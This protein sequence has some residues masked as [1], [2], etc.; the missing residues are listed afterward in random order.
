MRVAVEKIEGV[1]GAEV[2][3]NDG[4]VAIRL[5]DPNRVSLA[6]V[7]ETIRKQGFT[8]RDATVVVRGIARRN[9]GGLELRVPG[10]GDVYQLSGDSREVAEVEASGGGSVLL[11][12]VVSE[13]EPGRLRI[14]ADEGAP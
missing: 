6:A 1:A 4:R 14:L 2:S 12:G 3:L 9:G 10:S 5:D 11:R 13:A 7:R 8:P